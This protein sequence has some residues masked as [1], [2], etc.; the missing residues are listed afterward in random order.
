MANVLVVGAG[1]SGCVA[2]RMLAEKSYDVLLVDRRNHI[3]GNAYDAKSSAGITIQM[4]GP[5]IFHA[6]ERKVWDFLGRFTDWRYYQH[7]VQAYVEGQ[8]VPFPINVDTVNQLYNFTYHINDMGRFLEGFR[9]QVNR[10][11]NFR[12]TVVAR[13]GEELYD[14]FYRNYTQKL[15]GMDGEELPVALA[16]RQTARENRESR[17]F[18]DAYQGI[19]DQ[20][21]TAMFTAMLDH[22]NI[23][24]RLNCPYAGLPDHYKRLATVYS[25]CVDEYFDYRHGELPYRSLRFVFKTYDCERHQPAAVVHY[26]NDYDFA[27][28]TEF[29]YLTGESS[30]QTTVLYEY[31]CAEGDPYYPL[32]TLPAR[33]QYQKYAADA[34]L[35]KDIHFVGPLGTYR[36][37]DM[38]HAAIEAME[39][40]EN[41]FPSDA[42]DCSVVVLD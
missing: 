6:K 39:V 7:R 14:L 18:T 20:G 40:V 34:A 22:A 13:I 37:M 1:I 25:G 8:Y 27:R 19:P 41:R 29:K 21:Y 42:E 5:H 38:N 33:E 30:P 12:E 3:G 35:L 4:H 36:N 2:A 32:P 11:K 17:Y 31:P 26:P 9:P 28:T 16:G 10:A 23:E 15:W 24:T